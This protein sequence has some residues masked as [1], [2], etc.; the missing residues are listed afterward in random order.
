[1][2]ILTRTDTLWV[3]RLTQNGE[4][5]WSNKSTVMWAEKMPALEGESLQVMLCKAREERSGSTHISC[6]RSI[7]ADGVLRYMVIFFRSMTICITC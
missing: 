6:R 5:E 4:P 3:S 7:A 1:M 2:G